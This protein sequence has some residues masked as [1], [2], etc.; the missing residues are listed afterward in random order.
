VKWLQIG[1]TLLKTASDLHLK[2]GGNGPS[3]FQQLSQWLHSQD[4]Q[5]II[6]DINSLLEEAGIPLFIAIRRKI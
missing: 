2:S 6:V 4:G 3:F 1:G 5:N